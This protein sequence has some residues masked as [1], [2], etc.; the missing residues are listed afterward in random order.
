VGVNNPRR[1]RGEPSGRPTH[2]GKIVIALLVASVALALVIAYKFHLNLPSTLIT[3]VLGGGAPAILYL[4]WALFLV[5]YF[6]SR[7]DELKGLAEWADELASLVAKQWTKETLSRWFNDY[8]PLSVTWT[9]A[10]PALTVEWGDVVQAAM[11]GLASPPPPGTWAE[12]PQDLETDPQDLEMPGRA[13]ADL[14]ERI[15]T[16]R[17]VVLG[18]PGSGKTMLM[19]RLMIDML[20]R[21]KDRRDKHPHESEPVPVFVP[22]TTWDPD[23][24]DLRPWLQ[25]SLAIDYP[26]LARPFS[27]DEDPKS[28]LDALLDERLIVPVLDGLDEMPDDLQHKAIVKIN[29]AMDAAECPRQLLLTCRTD[30][31]ARAVGQHGHSYKLDGAAA[32]ELCELNP[33]QVGKYLSDGGKDV[34]WDGVVRELGRPTPVG[35]ALRTPLA[36]SLA[37]AIYNPHLDERPARKEPAGSQPADEHGQSDRF[38]LA[39]PAELAARDK[40]EGRPEVSFEYQF[41]G[42]PD[43][44]ELRDT[45]RFPTYTHIEDQLFDAFI[46]A[47]YRRSKGW[48]DEQAK[49]WLTIIADYLTKQGTT[50]LEW[51]DLKKELAPRWLVPAV[52]GGI[53]GLATGV[54]AAM[55]SHV[56]VGIG[57]GFGVGMLIALSIGVP[58]GRIKVNGKRYAGPPGPGMAGALGGAVGAIAAGYAH[59]VGIGHDPTLVSALPEALGIGIGGGA[60]T[61]PIGGVVG[62]L[63]GGFAGGLLEGIGLGLPA[64]IVNGL[65]VGMAVALAIWICGRRAPA[66]Q[67]PEWRPEIGIPGGIVIGVA[68]GLVAWR[69]EGL[70]AGIIMAVVIGV[71]AS[72]P[73]GLRDAE[74]ELDTIPS[75]VEAF[76]RDLQ[77]FKSTALKAG[78]A[79]GCAGFAGGGL[80]SAF[81]KAGA[82]ASLLMIVGDGLGI[83]IASGIVIGLTFGFYHAASPAFMVKNWWLAIQ[84]KAPWQLMRFLK[85]A[86]KKTVL[87]Q[88]G[89]NYQF[90]HEYLQRHL[91]DP[92]WTRAIPVRAAG[93]DPEKPSTEPTT[94]SSAG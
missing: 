12:G 30:E 17:L 29:E 13:L 48:T 11:R 14:L 62:G 26:P 1:R 68:L 55:G 42:L 19:L 37:V 7:K 80:S 75:P 81:E 6:D 5:A 2:V 10:N 85:D 39:D 40:A 22:L 61:R 43:P 33:Q 79:A 18:N 4:T 71:A 35:L 24:E 66:H 34:R 76:K 72:L 67:N 28:V 84:R 15:P 46:P 65:G 58:I 21:R 60:S 3:V 20:K 90:R 92:N 16:G 27:T 25:K 88:A 23:H 64:G 83:G 59:K 89:A 94:A 69:E 56:G 53:C 51:W 82:K 78:V 54:A 36:V 63:V 74:T 9:S 31:F 41:T 77:T 38:R 52:I 87:R 93:S 47:A 45:K 32:I 86:H 49:K 70:I 91:A 73:F 8:S 57:V 50:A 44:D